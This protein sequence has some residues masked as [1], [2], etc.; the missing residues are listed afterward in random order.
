MYRSFKPEDLMAVLEG[1]QDAVVKLDA[2]ANYLAMNIAAANIFRR[3]GHDPQQML[4]KSIWELF[5]DLNGTI[6]EQ[7]IR[8]MTEHDDHIEFEFFYP[9]DQRWYAARG[10]PSKQGAILI[11]REITQEKTTQSSQSSPR[12]S[13]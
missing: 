3:L 8:Q 12:S 9:M 4:G 5:P 13:I 11:F 10:Y 1:I 7:K 6:A 2:N